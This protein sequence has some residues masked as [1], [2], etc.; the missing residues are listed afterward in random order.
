[1]RIITNFWMLLSA[2]QLIIRALKNTFCLSIGILVI[3]SISISCNSRMVSRKDL[4]LGDSLSDSFSINDDSA[5]TLTIISNAAKVRTVKKIKERVIIINLIEKFDSIDHTGQFESEEMPF[6]NA[7]NNGFC[8]WSKE[9]FYDHKDLKM[10]LESSKS[11]IYPYCLKS[12]VWKKEYYWK[13]KL[14]YRF[15]QHTNYIYTTDTARISY[16]KNALGMKSRFEATE[17]REYF[18]KSNLVECLYK[19][20][21]SEK[22]V[23][24]YT[25]FDTIANRRCK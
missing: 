17:K 5:K 10:I 24:P 9:A 25:L 13:K 8:D 2:F 18:D 4:V 6:E 12:G 22:E 20:Y 19:S 16:L 1:M 14:L 23:N 21:D 7:D 15:V 3:I 11:V